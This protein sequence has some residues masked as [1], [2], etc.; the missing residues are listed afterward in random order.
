[1]WRTFPATQDRSSVSPSQRMGKRET[2][3]A[4]LCLNF[5]VTINDALCVGTTLLRLLMTRW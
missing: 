4:A 5:I 3:L 1:M 2:L